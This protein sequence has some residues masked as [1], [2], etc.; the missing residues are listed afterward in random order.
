MY[1]S[2]FLLVYSTLKWCSYI[3]II[4][5]KPRMQKNCKYIFTYLLK[6]KMFEIRGF[7]FL[8]CRG[9]YIRLYTVLYT[10][11]SRVAFLDEVVDV[12]DDDYNEYKR[13]VIGLITIRQNC[14]V[15]N[16][17]LFLSLF[18]SSFFTFLVFCVIIIFIVIIF[19][20]SKRAYY[21]YIKERRH[22]KRA[23]Y[24]GR[25][26]KKKY[27]NKMALPFFSRIG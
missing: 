14:L 1:V 3:R 12:D 20:I 13:T 6:R 21:Y 8:F 15:H 24:S 27:T 4:E 11:L 19:M 17:F 23:Y 22:R 16:S 7:F 9:K 26:R 10:I 25:K 18:L 2:L 5:W